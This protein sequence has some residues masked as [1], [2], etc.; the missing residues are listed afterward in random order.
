[1]V[2]HLLLLIEL[3]VSLLSSCDSQGDV[4]LLF[5][6][7]TTTIDF[8]NDTTTGSRYNLRDLLGDTWEIRRT[9]NGLVLEDGSNAAGDGDPFDDA[10][11]ILVENFVFNNGSKPFSNGDEKRVGSGP[12]AFF[13]ND[14]LVGVTEFRVV[15]NRPAVR[16][17]VSFLNQAATTKSYQ[18]Y[19]YSNLGSDDATHINATSSNDL[20]FGKTDR[21]LIVDDN[22]GPG[23]GDPDDP[24]V[25]MVWFGANAQL[26]PSS[27]YQSGEN[28]GVTFDL[29]IP[30]RERRSLMF[31]AEIHAKVANDGR[32]AARKDV[33][34]YDSQV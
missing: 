29:Q 21:W 18:V 19:I 20:T 15:P 3:S 6:T 8:A 22:T 33:G 12:H 25:T 13:A 34:F 27:S 9:S 7:T 17:L 5:N 16:V 11:K 14:E 26:S 28:I 32:S 4:D 23:T 30:S 10:F 24:V 2:F 31:F 1:M